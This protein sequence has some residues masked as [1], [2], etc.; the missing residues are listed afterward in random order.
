M[1]SGD[2]LGL[3]ARDQYRMPVCQ[4]RETRSLLHALKPEFVLPFKVHQ[5]LDHIH[6]SCIPISTPRLTNA[7][8]QPDTLQLLEH[9]YQSF[10]LLI[11]SI[12]LRE[13]FGVQPLTIPA[14]NRSM[15]ALTRY[16]RG[17]FGP[18]LGPTEASSV[19]LSR[20]G[21]IARRASST[22]SATT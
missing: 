13:D 7:G 20:D 11:V 6:T 19:I 3:P 17:V 16:G 2:G 8:T 9:V 18:E 21:L 10:S 5:R 4:S 12:L 14:S 22:G 1:L 15:T